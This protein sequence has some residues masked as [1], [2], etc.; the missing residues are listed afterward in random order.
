[1]KIEITISQLYWNPTI[2]KFFMR[3]QAY[4][5]FSECYKTM[6]AREE[7]GIWEW[8]EEE[9]EGDLEEFEEFCYKNTAEEISEA[10]KKFMGCQ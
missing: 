2:G 4:K 1:M 8:C 7:W 3:D 6:S 5:H 9:F 10:Y